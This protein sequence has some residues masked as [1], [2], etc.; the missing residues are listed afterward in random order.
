M[1]CTS[2]MVQWCEQLLQ[3]GQLDQRFDRG[4]F[5]SLSS[6]RLCIFGLHDALML[7]KKNFVTFFTI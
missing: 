1:L 3:V 6:E 4:W 5:S 2:I 7:F